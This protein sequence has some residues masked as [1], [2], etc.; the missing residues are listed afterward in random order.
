MPAESK[1]RQT[2]VPA[3]TVPVVVLPRSAAAYVPVFSFEGLNA[4]S[5]TLQVFTGLSASYRAT[6]TVVGLKSTRSLT[7]EEI[8]G[9]IGSLN[10]PTVNA[11]TVAQLLDLA[12]RAVLSAAEDSGVEIT[13]DALSVVSHAVSYSVRGALLKAG[14]DA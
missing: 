13:P 14:V 7:A 5:V 11:K 4:P 10:P 2:K 1:Q 9:G 6:I 3:P 12:V 8:L